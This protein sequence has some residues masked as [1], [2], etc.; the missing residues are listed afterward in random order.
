MWWWICSCCVYTQTFADTCYLTINEVWVH[1]IIL[2]LH[3]LCIL[4]GGG[5][6]GELLSTLVRGE[7]CSVCGRGGRQWGWVHKGKE[8]SKM[9]SLRRKKNLRWEGREWDPFSDG[10]NF[11]RIGKWG[12]LDFVL[13]PSPPSDREDN[14]WCYDNFVSARSLK[15]A[16]NVREQLSRIMDRFNLRRSSTEFTSKDYYLN[17]RKALV[18]G[19][20]MQVGRSDVDIPA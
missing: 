14:Q 2:P 11:M 6:K 12:C 3:K 15:S 16:D 18:S 10:G 19:F 5:D 20:F 4:S 7:V 8:E 9:L 13:I 17:I 1:N